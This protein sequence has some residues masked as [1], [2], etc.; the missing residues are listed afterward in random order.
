MFQHGVISVQQ[1]WGGHSPD[2]AFESLDASV[3]GQ[4]EVDQLGGGCWFIRR[5]AFDL[6]EPPYFVELFH[7]ETHMLMVSDD[8]YFQQKARELGCRLVCDT[9]FTIRHYH[10]VDLSMMAC[11]ENF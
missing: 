8:V 5:R 6:M 9:R 10:T 7:P 4:F 3:L 11:V 1:G 2:V